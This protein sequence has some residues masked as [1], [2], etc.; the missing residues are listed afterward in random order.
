[1]PS[2]TGAAA[3]AARPAAGP[4][5]AGGG[6]GRGGELASLPGV[7]RAG[8]P[9]AQRGVVG[10]QVMR[11]GAGDA[12]GDDVAWA[13]AGFMRRE[14]HQAVVAGAAGHAV[15][16][17]VLA[18]LALGDEDFDHGAVPLR[19]LL[20]RDLLDE[21]DEP[22]VTLLHD[23]L[24]HLDGHGPGR[25]ARANRVLEGQRGREPGLTYQVKRLREVLLCLAWEADDDVRGDRR[26]RDMRADVVQDRKVAVAAVGP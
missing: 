17:G 11:R 23:R 25:R 22:V 1:M 16:G 20:G 7:A 4:G 8:A 13:R 15:R 26:L 10:A 18:A 21:R 3:P 19:V 12:G 6:R 24:G 9:D 5:G 14:M 2:R